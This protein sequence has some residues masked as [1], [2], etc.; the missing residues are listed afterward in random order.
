MIISKGI[1]ERLESFGA[2]KR[3]FSAP[4]TIQLSTYPTGNGPLELP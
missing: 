2:E 3:T 1:H 4:T